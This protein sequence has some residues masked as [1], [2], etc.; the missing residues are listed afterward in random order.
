MTFSDYFF[1]FSVIFY[2]EAHL[3]Q[4]NVINS[5]DTPSALYY[6]KLKKAIY[7]LHIYI[8]LIANVKYISNVKSY[9]QVLRGI[10]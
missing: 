8:F 4:L 10:D 9:S 6:Y 7:N 1:N 2:C 3:N 5:A